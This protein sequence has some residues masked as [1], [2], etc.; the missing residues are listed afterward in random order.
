MP[1]SDGK[2]NLITPSSEQARR[3]GSKGGKKSAAVQKEKRTIREMLCDWAQRAVT[4][5]DKQALV[6]AGI[7]EEKTNIALLLA[8]QLVKAKAGDDKAA[9]LLLEYL[10]EDKKHEAE[11]ARLNAEIARLNAE[12]EK[13]KKQLEQGAIFD[14]GLN[15]AVTLTNLGGD[16]E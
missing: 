11:V 9:K 15:V 12:T 3:I 5:E 8:P 14:D 10:G 2:K 1:K 6:A 7:S 4:E 13:L 16:D